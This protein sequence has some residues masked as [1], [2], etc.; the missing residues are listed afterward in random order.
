MNLSTSDVALLVNQ[1]LDSRKYRSSGL[2]PATVEDLIYQEGRKH[3]SQKTILKAVKHKLHNIV[4]PYLG[5]LDYLALQA[6]LSNMNS[7][8]PNR[9]EIKTFCL[10]VLAQHASTAERI[11]F[12]T[13]FYRILFEEI[14]TPTSILDLACGLHPLAFPWMNLSTSTQFHAYDILQPRIDLINDFFQKIGMAALAENRDILVSPPPIHADL[15]IFFKEAHRFDKRQPGCNRAFW[16]HLKVDLLAVSLPVQN[17][18]GTHSLLEQHRRLVL[19]NLP[20]PK[21]VS[22]LIIENEIVFLIERPGQ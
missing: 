20:Q 8:D 17:L 5:E 11:P 3:N 7:G 14:G 4:A 2:N 21:F 13:E 12:M 1:I 18:S 22:E 6:Q 16:A 15:A 10:Q 19:E 9:Q